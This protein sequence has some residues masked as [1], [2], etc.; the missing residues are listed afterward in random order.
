MIRAICCLFITVAVL[1]PLSSFAKSPS[2]MIINSYHADY[3]WVLNHNT[4]LCNNLPADV[5]VSVH[6]LDVKRLPVEVALERAK[7][8][9]QVA[10]KTRPDVVVLTDDFA[11]RELGPF[12]ASEGLPVVF[13]G[14]NNNPRYYLG[15][16]LNATGVLERPLLKRSIVYIK[17]LLGGKLNTILVLFDDSVTSRATLDFVFRGKTTNTFAKTVSDLE[18]IKTFEQWKKVVLAAG[19]YDALITG[20]YHTLVD[21]KGNHVSAESVIRWTSANSP[22]PVFAFWDFSVGKGKALGG[23]VLAGYPQGWE[24]AELVKKV[25]AGTPAESLQPRMTTTGRFLFSWHELERWGI[26]LPEYFQ[27]TG[28]GVSYIQ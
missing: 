8:L 18:L 4:A 27:M 22:V 20:L 19:K 15:D 9:K 1:A 17:D 12:M 28:H 7:R 3:P 21:D 25:L 6:Y 14:I 16:M 5:D 11:L 10:A 23:F 26:E 2:V 13:L 24:A